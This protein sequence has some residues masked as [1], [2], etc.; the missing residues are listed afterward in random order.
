M[1]KNIRGKLN[2]IALVLAASLM[3]GCSG[4]KEEDLVPAEQPVYNAVAPKTTQVIRGDLTPQYSAR[5]DLLGYERSQYRFT[6]A[7]MEELYGTYQMKL[8]EIRVNIGD[9]VKKGDVMVS[10]HSEVLDKRIET[11]EKQISSAEREISHL[12]R[13]T[14]IDPSQDHREEINQLNRQIQVAKLY[15]SDVKETYEKLNIISD[16]D[17][18]VSSI[19][20]DLRE[21]YIT[22]ETSL[23]VVDTSKR[24]YMTDKSEDY[25]F[26]IGDKVT[27]KIRNTEYP[28]TVVAPPEGENQN[29]VYFEPEGMD[30]QI[31]EKSLMLEFE[32]PVRKDIC[33]VNR[34]A[35]YEKEGVTFVYVVG[36]NDVR[37]AEI[38]KVG[39]K[40]GNYYIIEEGLEGGELVELP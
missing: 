12:R 22:A 6:Q 34:Q 10:F 38:V 35:V 39:E 30:G 36:E 25:D 11:N 21:G 7:E 29:M 33:Y 13:L 1:R 19:N 4:A 14:S 9:A 24:L 27:A 18:F 23:V 28:L 5:L 15:I 16:V 20:P 3:T 2:I 40:V 32:L 17:G 8:D 31:L 26:K 37:H